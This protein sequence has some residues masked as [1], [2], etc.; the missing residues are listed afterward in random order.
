MKDYLPH[1]DQQLAQWTARFA[2]AV[3]LEPGSYGLTAAQAAEY[4]AA[5]R[6]FAQALVVATQPDTRTVLAVRAKDDAREVLIA[7]SRRLAG[8]VQVYP[9]TTNVMR[10]S[11]GLTIRKKRVRAVAVTT[12]RPS[13]RVVSTLGGR[14]KLHIGKRAGEAGGEGRARPTGAKGYTWFYFVGD[15]H[16]TSL[17]GWSFGGNEIDPKI[18]FTLP[19][20][21]PGA[22]VW[23][24]ANWFNNRMQPGPSSPPITTRVAGG[25][26]GTPGTISGSAPAN[27]GLAA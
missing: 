12:Q 16:P 10:L 19:G 15:T 2:K 13:V 27:L 11:L 7:L 22:K 26:T 4:D 25:W 9:G 3:T 17:A 20:I 18:E 5:Q 6:T 21:E 23:F 24:T 14:V 8:I 1:Q